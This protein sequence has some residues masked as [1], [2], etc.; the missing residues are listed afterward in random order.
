[1]HTSIRP[2]PNEFVVTAIST[3]VALV[4]GVM[5]AEADNER[6]SEVA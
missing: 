1:M 3:D 5:G 6:C 2:R 4:D